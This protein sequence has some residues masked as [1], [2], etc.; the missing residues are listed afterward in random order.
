MLLPPQELVRVDAGLFQN[1]PQ[2]P[3]RHI[4]RMVGDGGIAVGSGI[5]PDLVASRGLAIKLK[6]Q[7][8]QTLDDLAVWVTPRRPIQ[9]PTTSG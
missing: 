8:L 9:P 2:R 3:L 6:S 4:A 5:E 1:C 7:L